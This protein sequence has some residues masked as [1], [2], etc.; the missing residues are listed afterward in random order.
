[1]IEDQDKLLDKQLIW[2]RMLRNTGWLLGARALNAPLALFES[3]LLAHF[4]GVAGYGSLGLVMATVTAV[5]R[6]FSFRMN[7]FAVRYLAE[8]LETGDTDEAGA[9]LR[10]AMVVEVGSA[11]AACLVA[12]TA[13]PALARYFVSGSESVGLIRLF[14][15]IALANAGLET[16]TGALQ[17]FDRFRFIA[18]INVLRKGVLIAGLVTSFVIKG[19]PASALLA[20]V[21]ASLVANAT[22]L[23]AVVRTANQKF[24]IRWLVTPS[25]RTRTKWRE[26]SHFA[27]TTNLGATLGLVVKDSDLLWVGFFGSPVEAGYFKLATTLLKVPFAAGSPLTKAFYPEVARLVHTD[28]RQ[29]IRQFLKRGTLV[30]A[31]WIVPVAILTAV[32]APWMVETFYGP[33]FLPAVPALW[34]LLAGTTLAN[35]GFWTRP[36]LLALGRP[37]IPLRITLLNAVL[38][39]G[40]AFSVVPTWGYLGLSAI[41]SGLNINGL[42]LATLAIRKELRRDEEIELTN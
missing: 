8:A 35:I 39:V 19:G 12:Y 5:Q 27:L 3:V 33:S 28:S 31:G 26:M 22:A 34:I 10:L 38:K 2:P 21:V 15:L 23:T 1:M 42:T 20:Y 9:T 13:A 6:L 40:L 32:L 4:L 24:G 7:E 17:V 30:A 18:G 29:R 41:L 37:E 14:A 25:A 16:G 36:T 11:V